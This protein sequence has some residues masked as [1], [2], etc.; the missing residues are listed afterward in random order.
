MVSRSV[1]VN[2]TSDCSF[3]DFK[4]CFLTTGSW[5]VSLSSYGCRREFAKYER[6]NPASGHWHYLITFRLSK[7]M[8]GIKQS[9]SMASL[10]HRCAS[11]S[12]IDS[13]LRRVCSVTSQMTSKCGKNK[14]VVDE[15]LNEC[16]IDVLTTF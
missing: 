5:L 8:E 14:K 12:Q 13:M 10:C 11:V 3:N 1:T 7:P 16:V 9:L 6:S 4:L 2:F 15:P